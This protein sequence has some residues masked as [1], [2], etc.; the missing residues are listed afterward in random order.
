[1]SLINNML[2]DLD[3]RLE[4]CGQTSSLPVFEDLHPVQLTQENNFSKHTLLIGTFCILFVLAGGF[5]WFLQEYDAGELIPA[6]PLLITEYNHRVSLQQVEGAIHQNKIK[7]DTIGTTTEEIDS[8]KPGDTDTDNKLEPLILDRS[9]EPRQSISDNVL[10][11]T[12][13]P[14]SE[15]QKITESLP[16]PKTQPPETMI[17]PELLSPV[18]ADELLEES[19]HAVEHVKE[20]EPKIDGPSDERVQLSSDTQKEQTTPVTQAFQK[21]QSLTILVNENQDTVAISD[22][23]SVISQAEAASDPVNQKAV[24]GRSES[25][26]ENLKK[27]VRPMTEEELAENAYRQ[28][29]AYLDQGSINTAKS[30]LEQALNDNPQHIKTREELVKIMLQQGQRSRAK[31]ILEEGIALLPAHYPF[32]KNL[33]H[34]YADEGD[35]VRALALLENSLNNASDNA[36]Y[37][38]LISAI[39]QRTGNYAKAQTMYR[40]ALALKPGEVRWWLGLAIVSEAEQDWQTSYDAYLRVQNSPQMDRRLTQFVQEHLNTVRIHMK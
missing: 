32:A 26:E 18:P 17:K 21:D 12:E 10:A 13:I 19:Q 23:K 3:A 16:M 39:Y 33:A 11:V 8:V 27:V 7:I 20:I 28:A 24:P 30:K 6:F 1:M 34:L 5:I 38:G 40:R 31:R 14:Q 4:R 25:D 35:D 36:E 22:D 29:I 37:L 9:E 2:L 15:N